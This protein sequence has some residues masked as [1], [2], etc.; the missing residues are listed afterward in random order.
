MTAIGLTVVLVAGLCY[1]VREVVRVMEQRWREERRVAANERADV[2]D[3]KRRKVVVMERE[4][5]LRE[6]LAEKPDATVTIPPDLESRILAWE[7][8]WAQENER[9]TIRALYATTPDWDQVRAKLAPLN[10][11][12]VDTIAAPRDGMVN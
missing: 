1:G 8:T 10:A 3:V 7:D 5:T 2:L 11:G 9:Q 6:K 4:M 12:S